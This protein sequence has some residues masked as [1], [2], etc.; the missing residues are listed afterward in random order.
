[1]QTY[2]FTPSHGVFGVFMHATLASLASLIINIM[3]KYSLNA[4][5][6]FASLASE[7]VGRFRLVYDFRSICHPNRNT[8]APRSQ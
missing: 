8:P 7:L 2:P 3:W 4:E 1:M 5:V 6:H